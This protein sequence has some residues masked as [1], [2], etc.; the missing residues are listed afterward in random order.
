MATEL[1][2]GLTTTRMLL[3][4]VSAIAWLSDARDLTLGNLA[5][6]LVPNPS[7]ATLR[8]SSVSTKIKAFLLMHSF[9]FAHNEE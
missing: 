2:S 9:L 3:S 8:G 4:G 7:L 5:C 6:E 1:E